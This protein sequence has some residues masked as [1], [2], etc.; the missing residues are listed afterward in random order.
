MSKQQSPYSTQVGSHR[1]TSSFLKKGFKEKKVTKSG[2]VQ[3]HYATR[4]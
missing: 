4:K 2:D 3:T 1:Q